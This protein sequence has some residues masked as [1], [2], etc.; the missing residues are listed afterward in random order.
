M[1]PDDTG[2]GVNIMGKENVFLQSIGLWI[3]L[4]INHKIVFD[5][6]PLKIHIFADISLTQATSVKTK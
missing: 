5:Y 4:C 2:A 6:L 1:F 3:M